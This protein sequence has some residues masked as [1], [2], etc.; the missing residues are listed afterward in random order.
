MITLLHDAQKQFQ[1]IQTLLN[2]LHNDDL[3]TLSIATEEA[4]VLMNEGMCAST[5]VCHECAEHR[6]FIRKML[7]VLGNL[8][9][10][11]EPIETYGNEFSE[12]S[13][14]IDK[15]LKNIQI[16]LSSS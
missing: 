3:T 7:D 11:R 1:K 14:R 6:D 10:H 2:H 8:E 4:Y 16:A 13:V 5:S 12:Y 15:I 9:E